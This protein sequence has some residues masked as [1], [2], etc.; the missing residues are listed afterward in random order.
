MSTEITTSHWPSIETYPCCDSCGN[1]ECDWG[2]VVLLAVDFPFGE[3]IYV[4]HKEA[5]MWIIN[6][7]EG[8]S[9]DELE[10]PPSRWHPLP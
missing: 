5:G 7:G 9:C 10:V 2:P 1:A 8:I 6:T 4:G 3:M